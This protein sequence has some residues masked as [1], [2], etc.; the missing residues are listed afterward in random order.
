MAQVA[1]IASLLGTET[2]YGVSKYTASTSS[3]AIVYASRSAGAYTGASTCA[4]TGSY[5]AVF[6]YDATLAA[7]SDAAGI[8]AGTTGASAE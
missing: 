3:S 2:F 8:A 6:T 7:S 1:R 5:L 4:S